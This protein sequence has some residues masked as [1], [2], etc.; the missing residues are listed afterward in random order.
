MLS[1][2]V[3]GPPPLSSVV[4]GLPLLVDLRD[5]RWRVVDTTVSNRR[6]ALGLRRRPGLCRGLIAE[7]GVGVAFQRVGRIERPN[8]S[9]WLD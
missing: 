5:R 1:M 2:L 8:V 6:A 9:R 3:Y 4:P 7:C